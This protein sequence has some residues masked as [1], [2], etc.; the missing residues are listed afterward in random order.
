MEGWVFTGY[1]ALLY[2]YKIYNKLIKKE[3]LDRYSPS[4]VVLHLSRYRKAKAVG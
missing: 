4:D 3:L 2:C 1:L